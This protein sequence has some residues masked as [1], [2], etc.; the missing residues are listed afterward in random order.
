MKSYDESR[1]TPGVEKLKNILADQPTLILIDEIAHYL[2]KGAAVS[3]ADTTLARQTVV[4]LRELLDAAS[5]LPQCVIV[6]TLTSTQEAYGERTQQV[7]DALR[8]MQQITKRIATVEILTTEE[9]LHGVIKRRLFTRWDEKI[10]K[11]V[12]DELRQL[13][14]KVDAIPDP[15]RSAAYHERI[16][17]GYPFH[18]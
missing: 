8:E 1:Y 5:Q 18:P 16:L 7:L 14:Q 9:E 15:F 3:Y 17:A 10:A 6:L 2:E 12:A 4:F 11:Q 13:Y